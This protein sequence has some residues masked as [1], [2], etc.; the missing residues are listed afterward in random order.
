MGKTREEM[1]A[2]VVEVNNERVDMQSVEVRRKAEVSAADNRRGVESPG[3]H[4]AHAPPA[5]ST[6][7]PGKECLQEFVARRLLE[8]DTELE[9]S[10]AAVAECKENLAHAEHT[11]RQL[12]AEQRQLRMYVH[13]KGGEPWT[14][15]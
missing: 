13:P 14:K 1:L 15:K 5:A 10:K 7:P 8:M 11:H 9:D 3:E 4:G 12:V 2:G 6:V